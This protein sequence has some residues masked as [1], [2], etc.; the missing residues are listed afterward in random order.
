MFL[1]TNTSIQLNTLKILNIKYSFKNVLEKLMV[2][3]AIIALKTFS[4]YLLVWNKLTIITYNFVNM[5]TK[6]FIENI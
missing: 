6:Y 5:F 2:W 3:T 4:S 1:Y